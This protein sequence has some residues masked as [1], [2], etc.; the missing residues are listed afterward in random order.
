MKSFYNVAIDEYKDLVDEYEGWYSMHIISCLMPVGLLYILM[1]PT[2]RKS[3][4]LRHFGFLFSNVLYLL[5]VWVGINSP[6]IM[7]TLG[8]F[9]CEVLNYIRIISAEISLYLFIGSAWFM[10]GFYILLLITES[11][12]MSFPLSVFIS[13]IAIFAC[14]E[15]KS[16]Y[17]ITHTMCYSVLISIFIT[18]A[19]YFFIS[20]P[21]LKYIQSVSVINI[22][23]VFLCALSRKILA[24]YTKKLLHR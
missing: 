19:V 6:G 2:F 17:I 21:S 18:G 23:I 14:T 5:A 12:Y 7:F 10:Y 8:G 22:G 4:E 20:D 16:V 3:G 24:K 15:I 9:T 11:I 1:S 13:S